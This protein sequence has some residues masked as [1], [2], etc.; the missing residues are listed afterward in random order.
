MTIPYVANCQAHQPTT[1]EQDHFFTTFHSVLKRYIEW[2]L[3]YITSSFTETEE[4]VEWQFQKCH[5][6]HQCLPLLRD[7]G[8]SLCM[9]SDQYSG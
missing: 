9:A 7:F 4:S 2:G 5:L 8:S 3:G 6:E 1:V